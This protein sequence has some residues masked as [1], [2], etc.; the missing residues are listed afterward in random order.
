MGG[1][2]AEKSAAP[3]AEEPA[4]PTAATADE[5][6]AASKDEKPQF[7]ALYSYAGQHDDELP[8]NAGDIISL[9]SKEE[10]AWWKGEL[11]VA[12]EFSHL[13]MLKRLTVSKLFTLLAICFLILY[14][15]GILISLIFLITYTF[16]GWG[17]HTAF[18]NKFLLGI[19]FVP[20]KDSN[21]PD[22]FFRRRS[23]LMWITKHQINNFI[24][25]R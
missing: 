5:A 21:G 14:S 6:P 1:G 18:F 13:I 2:G 23:E 25:Y 7:R 4:A 8:F 15:F 19:F 12:S 11:D 20:S 17:S 22:F 24:V 10:E 3:A 9:I 16:I